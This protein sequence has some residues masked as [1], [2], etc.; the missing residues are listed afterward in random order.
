MNHDKVVVI[1][2]GIIG[3]SIAYYLAKKGISVTLFEKHEL[4]C[5]ASGSNQGGVPTQLFE[6]PLL[7]LVLESQKQFTELKEL[8]FDF[9]LDKCGS[10][11]C[12]T[13]ERQW[14]I[15]E[16]HTRKLQRSGVNVSLK[17][18]ADLRE[19][20]P[21]LSEDVLGASI[22]YEDFL[23]NPFKLTYA[24]AQAAEKLGG[25][26]Y[27]YTEVQK[28]VV[29]NGK[30]KSVVTSKGK[31]KTDYVVISA[32]AWSLLLLKG[33]KNLRLPVKP[34]RGQ[35][36]VT[37]AMPP[38]HFRQIIDADYLTTA[39]N[40]DIMRKSKDPRIKRGIA[41]TLVQTKSGNWLIGSSRD[42]V[43][44]DNRTTLSNLKLMVSRSLKFLPFLRYAN[45]LRTF[46]GLRP[47]SADDLPI[48]GEVAEVEGLL[49]ATGHCGEGVTLAPITGKIISEIILKGKTSI[50]IDKFSY[51]RFNSTSNEHTC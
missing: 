36:L 16:E 22:C 15:L 41:S 9:E 20:E 29:E 51:S 46:A 37:E 17:D 42:F 19:L 25:K 1:G 11:I 38:C 18:G 5:G 49:L 40:P 7:D 45:L 26:I 8:P 48:L 30:V 2:G 12:I 3:C 50:K 14:P 31:V 27:E 21:N 28:I 13:E 47:Y 32:G 34:Q 4:A 33:I 10:V 6:P 23:V 24:F 35:I 44:F 39:F 43:G